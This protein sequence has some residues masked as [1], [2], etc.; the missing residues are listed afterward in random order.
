MKNVAIPPDKAQLRNKIRKQRKHCTPE[1][2][3][4]ASQLI[5][6]QITAWPVFQTAQ[7][8]ASYMA[9]PHEVQTHLLHAAC[10]AQNKM[11]CV[12]CKKQDTYAWA[13]LCEGTILTTRAAGIQEPANPQWLSSIQPDLIFVP[14]V[15]VDHEGHRLG[16]GGGHYDR[17][18]ASHTG[19]K[20]ALAFSFQL[21]ASIPND[22]W[23]I[24][25]DAVVTQTTLE[26][27]K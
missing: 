25:M 11:L 15:A 27:F 19:F 2:I 23:D 4:T 9:M 24:S 26:Q 17:L 20:L 21:Q 16:H 1:W 5:Q 22:S 6:Q 12:P 18:L 3:T 7:S 13:Q 14:V 10:F 8:V